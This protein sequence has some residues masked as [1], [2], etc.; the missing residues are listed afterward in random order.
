MKIISA[1]NTNSIKTA[2]F[3]SCPKY[4][5]WIGNELKCKVY[6]VFPFKKNEFA[7][8]CLGHKIILKNI[9]PNKIFIQ[10]Q[11]IFLKIWDA[12]PLHILLCGG[13]ESFGYRW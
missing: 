9:S 7:L 6:T 4:Y 13:W 2:F 12:L 11:I 5:R 3:F 1:R 8:K 10:S